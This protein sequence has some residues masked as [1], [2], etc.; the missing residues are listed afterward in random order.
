VPLLLRIG[1]LPLALAKAVGSLDVELTQLVLLHAKAALPASELFELLLPH[2]T[3]Q[4]LLASCAEIGEVGPWLG[5]VGLWLG[6]VG[7]C[8]GEVVAEEWSYG[9]AKWA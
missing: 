4:R 2:P 1:A 6:E 8:L 3:A 9:S 5:E 7:L